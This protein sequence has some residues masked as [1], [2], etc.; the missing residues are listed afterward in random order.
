MVALKADPSVYGWTQEFGYESIVSSAPSFR[1]FGS[2]FLFAP[3]NKLFLIVGILVILCGGI[4]DKILA[5]F[6]VIFLTRGQI[7][8]ID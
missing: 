7:L 6:A 1:I 5:S 3:L 2:L 8:L 4:C